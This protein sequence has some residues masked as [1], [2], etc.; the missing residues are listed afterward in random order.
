M[1]FDSILFYTC[2]RTILFVLLL[3]YIN[4]NPSLFLTISSPFASSF[5]NYLLPLMALYLT[6]STFL[7]GI[8]SNFSLFF[9]IVSYLWASRSLSHPLCLCSNLLGS[10]S[11]SSSQ[12]Y[13]TLFIKWFIPE[14]ALLK[15]VNKSIYLLAEFPDFVPS[16]TTLFILVYLSPSIIQLTPNYKELTLLILPFAVG[17]SLTSSVSSTDSSSD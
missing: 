11:S 9:L 1:Y 10:N 2:F 17:N 3:L 16:A 13:L 6:S 14:G 12:T 4:I 8:V 7:T 5:Q 15:G